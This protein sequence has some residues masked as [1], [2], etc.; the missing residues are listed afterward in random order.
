MYQQH[1]DFNCTWCHLVSNDK[2]N[3]ALK[4]MTCFLNSM[5]RSWPRYIQKWCKF[6]KRAYF[7]RNMYL[8]IY[9]S[10]WVWFEKL[11]WLLDGSC[12][13]LK[14][15]LLVSMRITSQIAQAIRVENLNI[16]YDNLFR[17]LLPICLPN[18]FCLSKEIPRS[19]KGHPTPMYVWCVFQC[20]ASKFIDDD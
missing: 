13:I 18:S 2:L 12:S 8:I 14:P 7:K 16:I 17:I 11:M 5:Q 1:I 20:Q 15:S 6:W 10:L 4:K 19:I 3:S 9:Q